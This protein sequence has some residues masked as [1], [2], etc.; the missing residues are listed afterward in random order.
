MF[1]SHSLVQLHF[2][3]SGTG[4]GGG[5]GLINLWLQLCSFIDF[6]LYEHLFFLLIFF[7][8]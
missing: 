6:S 5:G 1:S 2:F 3:F 8:F 7:F 4:G